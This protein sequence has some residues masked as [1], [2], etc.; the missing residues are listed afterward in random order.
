MIVE[1]SVVPIGVG[2]SLSSYVS[3]VIKA[4]RDKKIKYQLNPMGTV[5]EVES[6]SELGELLDEVNER[7]KSMGVPRVYVVIKADWRR[8]ET[9]MEHKVK[10]VEEKLNQ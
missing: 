2:E 4:I 3:E 7:M 8:K 1:I 6:F 10:S 9:S 5:I